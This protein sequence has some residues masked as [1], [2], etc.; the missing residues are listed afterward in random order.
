MIKMSA[1]KKAIMTGCV[2]LSFASPLLVQG[3]Q[4]VQSPAYPVPPES[5]NTFTPPP[6]Q[7]PGMKAIM[8][9][10][11]MTGWRGLGR[12]MPN[13]A[14]ILP[15]DKMSRL[16]S[17]SSPEQRI[18][19]QGTEDGKSFGSVSLDVIPARVPL[20]LLV[21]MWDAKLKKDFSPGEEWVSKVEIASGD[22][23][24]NIMASL[25]K[26]SNTLVLTR[27]AEGVDGVYVLECR[28]D[29]KQLSK[30]QIAEWVE[31]LHGATLVPWDTAKNTIA[32]NDSA[33]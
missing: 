11:G 14:L 10:L 22:T 33:E 26:G 7:D 30:K 12:S 8:E 17:V 20:A 21:L 31:A 16:K 6:P 15:Q 23:P 4:P 29:T 24:G 25:R 28:L 18:V 3:K 32:R 5:N 19:L 1:K 27:F 9:E 13:F 2:V